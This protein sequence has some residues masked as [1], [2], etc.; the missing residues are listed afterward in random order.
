[1]ATSGA[2]SD[3][4]APRRG[5]EAAAP[6]ASVDPRR[7]RHR[8]GG[9]A[10]VEAGEARGDGKFYTKPD[11]LDAVAKALAE[12]KWRSSARLIWRAKN[13]SPSTTRGEARRRVGGLPRGA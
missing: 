9:R 7:R 6:N 10:E 3:F 1:M 4:A 8:G 11:D 12:R 13:P 2:V 5:V